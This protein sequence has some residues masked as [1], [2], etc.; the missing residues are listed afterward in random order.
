[1]ME[2]FLSNEKQAPVVGDAHLREFMMHVTP[3]NALILQIVREPGFFRI[4]KK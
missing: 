2:D 1:M 4:L 3:E